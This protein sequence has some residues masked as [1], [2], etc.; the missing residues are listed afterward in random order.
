[1]AT[2]RSGAG[3]SQ[4][5]ERLWWLNAAASMRLANDSMDGLQAWPITAVVPM[6]WVPFASS[7]DLPIRS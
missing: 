6:A 3:L 2:Q 4:A 1:M 5:S 7:T